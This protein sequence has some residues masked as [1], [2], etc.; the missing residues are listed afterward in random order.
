MQ[1]CGAFL[2]HRKAFSF[3]FSALTFGL[4]YRYRCTTC[5]IR[6]QYTVIRYGG[7]RYTIYGVQYDMRDCYPVCNM[8]VSV[9]RIRY[10]L[11]IRYPVYNVRYIRVSGIRYQVSSIQVS[12]IRYTVYRHQYAVYGIRYA[13]LSIQYTVYSLQST[14]WVYGLR[15]QITSVY[16]VQY[17][18]YTVY[19]MIYNIQYTR[20]TAVYNIRTWGIQYT[21]YS[22]QYQYPVYPVS[23]IQHTVYSHEYYV[24]RFTA[25][26][27]HAVLVIYS[28]R[29]GIRH[30]YTVQCQ[31]PVAR[32]T[33]TQSTV[34]GLRCTVYGIQST[35][36]V[37][38]VSGIRYPVHR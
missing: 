14:L 2:A 29:Y 37:Y 32:S 4:W 18:R 28:I 9:Y 20:Y 8:Q 27:W 22:I 1:Q 6:Y 11:S 26:R 13:G 35:V 23:S 10:Q 17:T 36:W 16:R 21:V 38:G 34:C 30:P 12:G 3:S 33:Y 15:Y 25:I 19:S 24:L 5:G 7:I 31:Y